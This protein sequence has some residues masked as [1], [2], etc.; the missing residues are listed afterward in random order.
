MGAG[1][2]GKQQ[3][4]SDSASKGR[5]GLQASFRAALGDRGKSL[6]GNFRILGCLA[7]ARVQRRYHRAGTSSRPGVLIQ[8][9]SV[10]LG[11]EEN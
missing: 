5:C 11:R 7:P 4:M 2:A 8:Y 1:E 3:G 10:V 9:R 6:A